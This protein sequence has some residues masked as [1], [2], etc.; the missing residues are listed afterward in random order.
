MKEWQ[1]DQ[2]PKSTRGWQRRDL[3][4]GP[5]GVEE[6]RSFRRWFGRG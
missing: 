2:M 6:R 1:A 3:R 4:H 5:K